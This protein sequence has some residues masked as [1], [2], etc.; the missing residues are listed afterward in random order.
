MLLRSYLAK[1]SLRRYVNS[2]GLP[3]SFLDPGTVLVSSSSFLLRKPKYGLVRLASLNPSLAI[4]VVQVNALN[5]AALLSNSLVRS[6]EDGCNPTIV[7]QSVMGTLKRSNRVLG[8]KL[9]LRALVLAPFARHKVWNYGYGK[10]N[11]AVARIKDVGKASLV[12]YMGLI[13]VSTAISSG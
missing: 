2:L 11:K 3:T 1:H 10:T 5:H 9:E 13:S 7:F 12:T 6:I 8:V 4:N